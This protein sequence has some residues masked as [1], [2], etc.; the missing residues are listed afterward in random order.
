[1]KVIQNK[2]L[3]N[4]LK[5]LATT[6]E[7][8]IV[9]PFITDNMV[10]HLLDNWKGNKIQVITR[11]NLNDFRSGVSSLKALRR[12]IEKDVEIKGIKDLHS[13]AYIF[14]ANSMIITSANFTNGGFFNNHELGIKSESEVQIKETLDYFN[15]LWSFN[16]DLLETNKINEWQK[17]IAENRITTAG[18]NLKDFGTSII[19]KVIGDKN[20]FIKFYGRGN[21]RANWNE[22]VVDIING[23]HCHFA[24]TFPEGIGRPTRYN[25]GDVVYLARM[26]EDQEYAI[27]GKAIARKHDRIRDIASNEDKKHI[28]WKE[29]FP[30]YIRVHSVKFLNTTFK[31]CPKMGVLMNELGYECFKKTKERHD[32]GEENIN[33]R[34]SLMRKPDIWLSEEGAF[35]VEQRFN[36]A[37][38]KFSL[39]PQTFI[40]GLYQGNPK[41]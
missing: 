5:E 29:E 11:Y 39:V 41:I 28:E 26:I 21:E 15:K 1:M 20:Y 17:I 27:F 18:A 7:L 4:F 9:S 24:I 34:L 12:L 10:T 31:N 38:K 35:W 3:D 25:E 19:R 8:K 6:K 36:E 32:N 33:P 22:D 14:D 16:N 30:I 13:K 2:W 40:D 23:T 37:K